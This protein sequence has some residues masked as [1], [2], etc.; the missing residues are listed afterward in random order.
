MRLKAGKGSR[1]GAEVAENGHWNGKPASHL[2]VH[3]CRR[4]NVRDRPFSPRSPR[5]RV[6]SL[7]HGSGLADPGYRLPSIR[8]EDRPR[9]LGRV[10]RSRRGRHPRTHAGST[11]LER[12]SV[13]A[14]LSLTSLPLRRGCKPPNP[15]PPPKPP[16]RTRPGPTSPP[17][18][19]APGRVPVTPSR[20]SE[21][22][23]PVPP[24][25]P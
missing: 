20:P 24:P 5:L 4:R 2:M 11:H 3:G 6:K 19:T 21:G 16:P 14:N 25:T 10:E 22:R 9:P 17:P 8:D 23:S 18:P 13:D 12:G 1:G 15:I 7:L